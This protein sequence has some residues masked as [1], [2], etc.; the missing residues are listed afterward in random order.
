MFAYLDRHGIMHITSQENDTY[1]NVETTHSADGGFPTVN[2]EKV[3]IYSLD[4]AYLGGNRS[5]FEAIP[6]QAEKI[7]LS[8]Y[9][10]LKGL[11]MNLLTE[12]N[13]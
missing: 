10:E 3:Y 8:D 6:P 13:F 7:D 2:G 11:Y 12:N 9:P 4:E 5:S 1:F